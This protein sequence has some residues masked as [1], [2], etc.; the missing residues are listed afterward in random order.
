MEEIRRKAQEI[1]KENLRPEIISIVD[2]YQDELLKQIKD[3]SSKQTEWVWD[4]TK[5]AEIRKAVVAGAAYVGVQGMI[6]RIADDAMNRAQPQ[7][8]EAVNTFR[9]IISEATVDA[10]SEV[11]QEEINRQTKGAG[12]ATS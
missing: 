10:I 7:I 5:I 4:K 8:D 3:I 11:I 9:K 6:R 2:K 12:D 1:M